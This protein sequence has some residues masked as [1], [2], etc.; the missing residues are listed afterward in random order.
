MTLPA[1]V[2]GTCPPALTP[3]ETCWA[4]PTFPFICFLL[5]GTPCSGHP[6]CLAYS[7][8]PCLDPQDPAW[9][10][11]L[12]LSDLSHTSALPR[13]LPSVLQIQQMLLPQALCTCRVLGFKAQPTLH[14]GASSDRPSGTHSQS[15]YVLTWLYLLPVCTCT[16]VTLGSRQGLVHVCHWVPMLDQCPAQGRS[17]TQSP[18]PPAQR[19]GLF[20][21]QTAERERATHSLWGRSSRL[22][23]CLWCLSGHPQR[24]ER[25]GALIPE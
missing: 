6:P 23:W 17:P 3:Q 20:S 16:D 24:C 22:L 21:A 7:M 4:H 18:R 13:S 8:F 11:S 2:K 19:G 25:V 5:E 14:S 15:L 9:T 12:C 1:V 10:G